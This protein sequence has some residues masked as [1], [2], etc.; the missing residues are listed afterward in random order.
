MKN[1]LIMLAL[2]AVY[3][4]AGPVSHFGM[5]KTCKIGTKGQICSKDGN[6]VFFK[7]PSLYWS[8]GSGKPFY[9][10]QTVD[11]FVDNMQIGVIRAAMAIQYYEDNNQPVNKPGGTWGYYFRPEE[12]KRLIK[13]IIEAAIVNDIYVVVDW[14]SHNAHQNTEPALAREFFKE[15]A[16]EYKDVPNIIW[17]IY[18]E[19]MSGTQAGTITSHANSVINEI[20]N[21]GNNNLVLVGS[22]AWSQ[23]PN[24]QASNMAPGVDKNIAFTFHFYAAEG[25]GSGHDGVMTSAN[26]AMSAGY[27][28]FGSEWG[29]TEASGQGSLNNASKWTSWMDNNKISNC[30]W[31]VSN[32][33]PS[34]MFS[35]GTTPSNM[36]TTRLSTSGG[37]FNSYMN[38]NKWTDQIPSNHPKAKDLVVTVKDGES[39]TLNATTLGLTGNVTEISV[40][41]K[42]GVASVAAD[43]K[44]ITYQALNTAGTKTMF[45]YK[46][47]QNSVTIQNRVTVTITDR[48]KPTLP[49]IEPITV[50]NKE[51]DS[52]PRSLLNISSPNGQVTVLTAVSISPSSAGTVELGNNDRTIYFTPS[53]SLQDVDYTEAVLTY[54]VKNRDD[55]NSSTASVT[56]LIQNLDPPDEPVRAIDSWLL[57]SGSFG[58]KALGAGKVELNFSQSGHAKLDVYS[59]SGKNM[60]TL[61]NGYQ[62]AGS[63]E[64]AL[65]GLQKGVYILRLKQGSQ[66]KTLRIMN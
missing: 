38:T 14:H 11:W 25:G 53:A 41:P 7:G 13:T 5:L 55:A 46:T 58:I 27:A 1:L 3:A 2:L 40:L 44:S 32:I 43:G 10:Q 22:R 60:G 31:S 56:L 48:V 62:N 35:S 39:V 30:N 51:K 24:E 16:T 34:S 37:Y 57:H 8:D 61:L 65:S 63:A 52:I 12:Q 6:A 59:L 18:N 4:F 9:N 29:F 45:I 36:A 42:F 66:V 19:P 64:L 15:M 26:S 21:A 54:T 17:E 47:T 33:E 50:N 20:R 23:N 49:E 28:V